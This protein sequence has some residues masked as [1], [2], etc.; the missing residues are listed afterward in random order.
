MAERLTPV[1][2]TIFARHP[3]SDPET[4]DPDSQQHAHPP[5]RKARRVE[6]PGGANHDP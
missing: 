4:Q 3:P 2:A 5:G 6:T 1:R